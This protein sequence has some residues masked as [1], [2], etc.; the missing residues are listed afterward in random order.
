MDSF[1]GLFLG[2]RLRRPVP[3]LSHVT[4]LAPLLISRGAKQI[5]CSGPAHMTPEPG[6]PGCSILLGD[7]RN[8]LQKTWLGSEESPEDVLTSGG[9]QQMAQFKVNGPLP[10]ILNDQLLGSLLLNMN[11]RLR[12]IRH[13]R[14]PLHM[15]N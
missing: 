5:V 10:N 9:P 15:K 13:L 7:W 8:L 3:V 1:E 14:I 4:G 12:N 6:Q 11:R 2:C